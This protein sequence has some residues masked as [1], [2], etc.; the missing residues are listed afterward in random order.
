ML[1]AST[2]SVD[3]L[4]G[5]DDW[6]RIQEARDSAAITAEDYRDEMVNL[7]RWRLERVLRYKL[8]A[9]IPMRMPS[10]MPIYDMVFATD[11]PVGDKIMTDLYRRA[12]EREPR[13]RQEAKARARKER[14]KESG[15]SALF[16]LDPAVI[17]IDHLTWEPSTSWDPSTRPWWR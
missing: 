11:H 3:A 7:L 13:M 14:D 8:T 16:D 9:R 10:G 4:Y 15:Q 17:R 5:G 12:A 1:P 6:R 2:R